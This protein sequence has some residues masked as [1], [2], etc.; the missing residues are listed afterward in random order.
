MED[1]IKFKKGR[2]DKKI[3]WDI[4]YEIVL[5][6]K[7]IHAANLV[8][9]DLKPAN[10]FIDEAGCIKIGDFGISAQTPVVRHK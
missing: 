8:H 4:F 5:G 10:I 6:V 3:V 7:D 1:Y 9:L 2:I